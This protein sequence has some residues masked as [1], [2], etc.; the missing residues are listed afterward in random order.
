MEKQ[1]IIEESAH[2]LRNRRLKVT[3]VRSQFLALLLQNEKAV[4]GHEIQSQLESM[5][6]VTLYR[7]IRTLLDHG[8]IHKAMVE[9]NETYYAIC[10]DACEAG[11]HKHHHIHFKCTYCGDIHC[12]E[13]HDQMNLNL[14]GYRIDQWE[15][16]ASGVC[17]SCM[18][19]N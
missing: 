9:G 6:R 1:D 19:R 2:L 12:L 14:A 7:T 10:K 4:S 13:M 5:D 11:D 3:E 17:E 8:V 15:V 18:N 16:Q